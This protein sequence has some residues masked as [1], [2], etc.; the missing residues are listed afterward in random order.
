MLEFK[1]FRLFNGKEGQI[2]FVDY[3]LVNE[4]VDSV[5][6]TGK[7]PNKKDMVIYLPK[8]F[9]SKFTSAVENAPIRD[10]QCTVKGLE[11]TT[12][13]IYKIGRN[14]N[15]TGNITMN[16]F[17]P[18]LFSHLKV[19]QNDESEEVYLFINSFEGYS[20][21]SLENRLKL[22]QADMENLVSDSWGTSEFEEKSFFLKKINLYIQQNLAENI[23]TELSMLF[24]SVT[25]FSNS[26]I[27]S[28]FVEDNFGKVI[29]SSFHPLNKLIQLN[30]NAEV[31]AVFCSGN[32]CV[33]ART[34]GR[35][36]FNGDSENEKGTLV[37]IGSNL[38]TMED[39]TFSLPIISRSYSIK[40]LERF[41][42]VYHLVANLPKD[43]TNFKPLLEGN[44][45]LV[46]DYLL[47]TNHSIEGEDVMVDF[48]NRIF[49]QLWE[50][51]YDF[52]EDMKLSS[53]ETSRTPPNHR[54]DNFYP[55]T[56]VHSS[57]PFS[58]GLSSF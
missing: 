2:A 49:F 29:H 45:D 16:S 41:L 43:R 36:Q 51:F 10:F 4:S 12:T 48:L 25:L 8:E 50:K 3:S 20:K 52:L 44:K 9:Q 6:F 42:K 17:E 14:T 39:N 7:F 33:Q 34:K 37:I 54:R 47:G 31:E 19:Y 53:R 15:Q 22:F 55:L 26:S 57:V 21:T 58:R 35:F 27:V 38:E 28:E 5:S 40:Y 1:N 56:K 13:N 30:K 24:K 18:K 11:G 46:F 32:S 23:V